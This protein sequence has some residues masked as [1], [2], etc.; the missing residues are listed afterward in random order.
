M[1]EIRSVT[2]GGLTIIV[3]LLLCTVLGWRNYG[4]PGQTAVA[5]FGY[6]QV[7]A[8]LWLAVASVI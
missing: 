1:R 4:V 8:L 3:A 6:L 5:T 7:A 2:A